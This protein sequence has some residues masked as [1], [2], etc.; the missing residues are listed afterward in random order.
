MFL[1]TATVALFA[2]ALRSRR[3]VTLDESGLL[4]QRGR[5]QIL[6]PWHGLTHDK[7]LKFENVLG[8]QRLN[9]KALIDGCKITTS[10]NWIFG[11]GLPALEI[12]LAVQPWIERA[13][14]SA[15]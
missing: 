5:R 2:M 3:R 15:R 14:V 12:Y 1:M 8:W 11:V 7:A 10:I 9:I 13:R 6:I 4:L